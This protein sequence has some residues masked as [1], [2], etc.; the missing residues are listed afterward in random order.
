MIYHSDPYHSEAIPPGVP[1]STGELKLSEESSTAPEPVGKTENERGICF[2][3]ESISEDKPNSASGECKARSCTEC[4]L[5]RS[6]GRVAPVFCAASVTALD[7]HDALRKQGVVVVKGLIDAEKAALWIEETLGTRTVRQPQGSHY[8]D[9]K[10]KED[11]KMLSDAQGMVPLP[12]HVDGS[13]DEVTPVVV[14]LYCKEQSSQPEA[15]CV[16]SLRDFILN[17][18][19]DEERAWL[20]TYQHQWGHTFESRGRRPVLAPIVSV[21]NADIMCRWSHNLLRTGQSSPNVEAGGFSFVPHELSVV[22]TERLDAYLEDRRN[23]VEAV[24]DQGDLVLI[25]NRAHVHF[26]GAL[27]SLQR[28]FVRFWEV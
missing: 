27:K 16:A 3:S 23:Y 19:T 6:C 1:V 22:L 8:T 14:G 4:P 13:Q 25:E 26:R 12:P 28:W 21:L 2:R 24:A 7:L 15:T 17:C 11:R 20:A 5:R 10:P 9:V 18:C